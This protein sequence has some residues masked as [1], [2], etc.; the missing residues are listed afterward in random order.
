MERYDR[1]VTSDLSVSLVYL[2]S[3][4]RRC[5]PPYTEIVAPPRPSGIF[6]THPLHL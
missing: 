6:L 4:V 2:S 3:N 1:C 5:P